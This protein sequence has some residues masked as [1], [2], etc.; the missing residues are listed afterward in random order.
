MRGRA[1]GHSGQ[2]PTALTPTLSP[3][4]RGEGVLCNSESEFNVFRGLRRDF[5]AVVAS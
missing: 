1:S 3:P 4:R 2:S 5:R